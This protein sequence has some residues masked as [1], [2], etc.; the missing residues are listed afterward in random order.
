MGANWRGIWVS[1]TIYAVG[2]GVAGSDGNLYISNVADNVGHDPTTDRVR[3]SPL[4]TASTSWP[5]WSGSFAEVSL[6]DPRFG[7]KGDGIT[8]D[9][10]AIQA[11][12]EGAGA[13]GI[14][15][16]IRIPAFNADGTNGPTTAQSRFTSTAARTSLS[17]AAV[18]ASGRSSCSPPASTDSCS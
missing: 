6:L 13:H 18:P 7:V 3:W 9:I 10:A 8:D 15:T 4:P 5:G 12:I 1:G 17:R 16:T 11:V 2:D 14:G